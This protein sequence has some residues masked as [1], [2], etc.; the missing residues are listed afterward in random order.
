LIWIVR[1]TILWTTS[2]HFYCTF[3]SWSVLHVETSFNK[4][5]LLWKRRRDEKRTQNKFLDI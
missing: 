5:R 4:S 1:Y 2:I 3:Y